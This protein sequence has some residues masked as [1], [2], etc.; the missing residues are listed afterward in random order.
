MQ[1]H[2]YEITDPIAGFEE[3]DVLDVTSRFGDWHTYEL[4]LEVNPTVPGRKT[5]VVT[6][7]DAGFSEAEILDE[8]ARIGDWHEYDLKFE[9][10]RSA[11]ETTPSGQIRL[12]KDELERIAEPVSPS[13]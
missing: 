5:V 11:F 4:K 3:G 6:G 10:G 9:P 8:T 2:N 12:T 7:E 1:A 13:A